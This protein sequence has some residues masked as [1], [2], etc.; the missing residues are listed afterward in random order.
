MSLLEKNSSQVSAFR[1]RSRVGQVNVEEIQHLRGE[2]DLLKVE[3]NHLKDQLRRAEEDVRQA[4]DA[5]A[6]LEANIDAQRK[7]ASKAINHAKEL[8]RK[9]KTSETAHEEVVASL[10]ETKNA[11]ERFER[12]LKGRKYIQHFKVN[13]AD[14]KSE[15]DEILENLDKANLSLKKKEN[16]LETTNLRVRT[17]EEEKSKLEEELTQLAALVEEVK[18]NKESDAGGRCPVLL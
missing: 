16:D 3:N 11:L 17:L 9:L 7:E 2:Y 1:D 4:Q 15:K 6:Q 8:E 10:R 18:N 5:K 13:S 14:A 12:E